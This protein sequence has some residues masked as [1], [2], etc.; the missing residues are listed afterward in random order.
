M[1]NQKILLMAMVK[2]LPFGAEDSRRSDYYIKIMEDGFETA[3]QP[4]AVVHG[5]YEYN[6]MTGI[7][8]LS[9]GATLR[10]NTRGYTYIDD[11]NRIRMIDYVADRTLIA[12]LKGTAPVVIPG[13]Y[14]MDIIF[15]LE[16]FSDMTCTLTQSVSKTVFGGTWSKDDEGDYQINLEHVHVSGCATDAGTIIA[17]I[18]GYLGGINFS[19]VLS[20][21]EGKA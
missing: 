8:S 14:T 1:D 7:F 4:G 9:N 11:Q 3:I 17:K 21:Q 19:A 15:T 10:R 20:G 2:E 13:G 18:E 6:P 16:I 12:Q 5:T